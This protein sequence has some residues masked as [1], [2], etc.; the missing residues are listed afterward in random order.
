VNA[1]LARFTTAPAPQGGRS[2]HPGEMEN[3][4]VMKSAFKAQACRVLLA[5]GALASSALV[6]EAGKRWT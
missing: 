3:R 2:T 5:L 1:D 6:L 4:Y